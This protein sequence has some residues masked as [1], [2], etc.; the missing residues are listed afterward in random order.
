MAE[1]D[2]LFQSL[3]MLAVPDSLQTTQTKLDNAYR[4]IIWPARKFKFS[5]IILQK[6][7]FGEEI[8]QTI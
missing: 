1:M 3:S 6:C 7:Q 2:V 5:L 4:Y 8:Y